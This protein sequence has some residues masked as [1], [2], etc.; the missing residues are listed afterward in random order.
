[1]TGKFYP[2]LQVNF[3]PFTLCW[4]DAEVNQSDHNKT[5]QKQLRTIVK[6]LTVFDDEQRCRTM[7][8]AFNKQERLILIVSG[9][10]GQTLVR[11][12]HSLP[13]LTSIYIY[14]RDKTL[15]EHWARQFFKVKFVFLSPSSREEIS[16]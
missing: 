1:M 11:D 6:Q 7:I 14:C 12:I 3:Q 10:L 15:H 2:D 16:V 13:Q 5:V 8:E 9:R 4:L